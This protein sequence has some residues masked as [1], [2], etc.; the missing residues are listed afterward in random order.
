MRKIL[1]VDDELEICL[2]VTQYLKKLGYETDFALS[3]S[4]ALSK[5]SGSP[6]DILFVD[7]NLTDGSGYDLISTLQESKNASKIIVISAYD[8]ERQKALQKGASVF[9]AKPFTIKGIDESLQKLN[10]I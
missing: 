5:I 3:I 8:S 2:L 9:L 4:E 7:L 1:V 10:F 6:F